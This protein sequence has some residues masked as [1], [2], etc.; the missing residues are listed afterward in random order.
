MSNPEYKCLFKEPAKPLKSE[1]GE[2]VLMGL[3]IELPT[4]RLFAAAN[5]TLDGHTLML[6][7][8]ESDGTQT[9]IPISKL[10]NSLKDIKL[11]ENFSD[12]QPPPSG[13]FVVEVE[14]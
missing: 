12:G 7:K 9:L 13:H 2:V 6:V 1:A 5:P 3:F 10:M 11:I 8:D 4:N 14:L